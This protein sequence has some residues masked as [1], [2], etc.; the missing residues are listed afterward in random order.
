MADIITF[1]LKTS[2]LSFAE[3]IENLA[4]IRVGILENTVP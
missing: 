3:P 4:D 2:A 1:E